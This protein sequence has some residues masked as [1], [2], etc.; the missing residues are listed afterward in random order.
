MEIRPRIV[1]DTNVIVSHLLLAKS[2]PGRA[3]RKAIHEGELLISEATLQELAEVLARPKFDPYVS[4]TRRV[5]FL[6]ALGRNTEFVAI[7]R[8]ITICRDPKDDKFLELA[9]NGD[10]SLI[11]TGDA[12]MLALHP[13]Q[14][15]PIITPTQYLN[16]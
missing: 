9:V 14:G 13:F 1:V 3:V 15:I 7:V 2:I 8:S 12:D 5:E 10:A 4:M 16:T 11:I 6:R